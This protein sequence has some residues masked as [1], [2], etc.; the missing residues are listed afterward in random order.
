M[1]IFLDL[2]QKMLKDFGIWTSFFVLIGFVVH[3]RKDWKKTLVLTSF[4]LVLFYFTSN[5]KAYAA[6]NILVIYAFYSLFVA[7]GAII[8]FNWL[9]LTLKKIQLPT[10]LKSLSPLLSFVII[11][12]LL[13]NFTP[14]DN[15]LNTTTV[16]PDS[17]VLSVDWIKNNIAKN[18]TIIIPEELGFDKRP[19][20]RNY[21]IVEWPMK[22]LNENTFFKE[23]ITFRNPHVLMPFFCHDRRHNPN[24]SSAELAYRLNNFFKHLNVLKVFPGNYRKESYYEPVINQ[25]L[26]ER[27]DYKQSEGGFVTGCTFVD[28]PGKFPCIPDGFPEIAIGRLILPINRPVNLTSSLMQGE[29]SDQHNTDIFFPQN[30]KLQSPPLLFKK[31]AYDLFLAGRIAKTSTESIE[32]VVRNETNEILTSLKVKEK[33]FRKKTTLQFKEDQTHSITV[34]LH[35]NSVNERQNNDSTVSIKPI[36]V[37]PTNSILNNIQQNRVHTILDLEKD[38]SRIKTINIRS[39]NFSEKGWLLTVDSLDPMLLLPEFETTNDFPPLVV[40]TSIT[41][42]A[43]TFIAIYYLTKA[44]QQYSQ[45]RM[46]TK[47]LLKGYNKLKIALPAKVIIGRLRLD[48]GDIPGN[49]LINSIK[50][51]REYHKYSSFFAEKNSSQ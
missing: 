7:L 40:E 13:Y 29:I 22:E 34:E 30:R 6:R 15:F 25:S 44:N 36:L 4:P 8:A 18:S 20:Q 33:S 46:V 16:Q 23:M 45:T 32:L 37:S 12:L 17:R 1:E 48:P 5:M 19:L 11:G 26:L 9:N 35:S 38:F 41:A 49:Y 10:Q 28:K 3:L 2:M 43:E 24:N 51:G 31:G 21:H 39:A 50:I 14:V 42:P 47:R 27:T